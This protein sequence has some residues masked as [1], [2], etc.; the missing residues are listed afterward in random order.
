MV[1]SI[2][3]VS[4]GGKTTITELL[5]KTLQRSKALFFDDYNFD[6]PTDIVK[7]INRGANPNEWDLTPFIEDLQALSKEFLDYVIIDFPFSYTHSQINYL[8]NIS[9]FIDTPLDIAM[10]RRVIRDHSDSSTEIILSDMENYLLRGRS[11]YVHM[12]NTIKPNVD[13]VVDGT[14]DKVEIINVI[15]RDLSISL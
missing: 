9:V 5:N 14:L 1:I 11:G 12:L 7:W 8:I 15:R 6:G 4:G 2:S 10:V 13:L 3:A